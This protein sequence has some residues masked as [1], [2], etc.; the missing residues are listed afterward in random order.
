MKKGLKLM[1]VSGVIT[2]G[3]WMDAASSASAFGI[4]L[5]SET[6]AK[7]N[8]NLQSQILNSELQLD[9]GVTGDVNTGLSLSLEGEDDSVSLK[10]HLQGTTE[11]D[12]KG[13][14]EIRGAAETDGS[15]G[16]EGKAGAEVNGKTSAEGSIDNAKT[17][18]KADA[19]DETTVETSANVN[20]SSNADASGK[21]NTS[22]ANAC[23]KE[24]LLGNVKAKTSTNAKASLSVD[25]DVSADASA[26]ARAGVN[27]TIQTAAAAFAQKQAEIQANAELSAASELEL[28]A[29]EQFILD[30]SNTLG[31][32]LQ[33]NLN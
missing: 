31:I 25:E 20:G 12:T 18:V 10:K 28:N 16:L 29:F 21:A 5:G 24:E 11:L 8:S 13:S 2:V 17:S 14:L 1:V 15:A 30:L 26:E 4:E 27:Q 33:V 9:S 19:G 23:T 22:F 7:I 32:G 6:D 3:L